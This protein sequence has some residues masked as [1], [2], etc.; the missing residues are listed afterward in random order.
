MGKTS[1]W[2]NV[3]DPV[4]DSLATRFVTEQRSTE[5]ESDGESDSDSESESESDNIFEHPSLSATLIL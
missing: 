5:S 3:A 2:R 1:R 4:E